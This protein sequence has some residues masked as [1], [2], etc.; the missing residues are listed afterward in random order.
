MTIGSLFQCK[1]GI[2]WCSFTNICLFELH[3]FTF[4]FGSLL[5]LCVSQHN[6]N[7]PLQESYSS[8]WVFWHRMTSQSFTREKET[9]GRQ[10]QEWV[11]SLRP[12]AAGAA[13]A[14]HGSDR[15]GPGSQGLSQH[16][17]QEQAVGAPWTALRQQAPPW[18]WGKA[19]LG[20]GPVGGPMADQN[21][22]VGSWRAIKQG[23]C[24]GMS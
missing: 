12:R 1:T 15:A 24:L 11:G 6:V 16:P 8:D 19:R 18:G 17:S 21:R 20:Y 13:R 9:G 14:L 5:P 23:C 4:N 22:P 3:T 7:S 2:K 10:Q